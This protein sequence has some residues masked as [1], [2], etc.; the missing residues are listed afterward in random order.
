MISLGK[1]EGTQ[2]KKCNQKQYSAVSYN[3]IYIVYCFKQLYWENG[4][5]EDIC[6]RTK[7]VFFIIESQKK[8]WYIKGGFCYQSADFTG[9]KW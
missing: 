4:G 9:Q 2:V 8:N 1:I 7:C 6:K 3:H 5:R